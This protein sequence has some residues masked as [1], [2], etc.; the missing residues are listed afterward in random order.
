MIVGLYEPKVSGSQVDDLCCRFGFD[1]WL[2]IEAVGFSGGIWIFWFLKLRL[3][4]CRQI[5]SLSF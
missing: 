3:K 4:C 2:C 1:Q 5:L